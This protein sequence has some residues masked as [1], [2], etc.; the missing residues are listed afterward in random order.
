M[1]YIKSN[2]EAWEEAFENR[3][4]GWGEDICIRLKNEAYPYLEKD[5]IEEFKKFDF[6]NK[7][8][9][10]FCCNN[11]RELL[12]M[13]KFGAKQGVGFDIAENMV[14]W[15][16]KIAEKTNINCF[17][18]A[19][20]ILEIDH[21]Y[22][23]SFDLVFISAGALTW[24]QDLNLLFNKI[25]CCLKTGGILIINEMHP[26]TNMLGMPGEQNYDEK[27]PNKLVNSYFKSDPWIENSGM[28]YMSKRYYKSKTFYCYAHTFS[29]IINSLVS[30]SITILKLQEFQYDISSSFDNLN[31]QGIPLSYILTA[32]K[33]T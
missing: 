27:S 8:I 2:K 11:G 9:S 19:T 13:L 22:Y 4:Q 31:N 21:K 10:Q 25:S 17:F 32:K 18:E 23:N 20:D 14:S 3:S 16:N 28:S 29:D 30:N 26:F 5:L 33:V 24:F 6:T 7:V 1:E 12:S 15:A